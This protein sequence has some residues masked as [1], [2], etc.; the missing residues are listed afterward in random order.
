MAE[1][2]KLE[3]ISSVE[4]MNTPMKKQRFIVD[5]MIYPGL[6]ILSGDPK[7][8]KSWMMLDMCLA[9][10][11][12]EKF[13]GRKTERGQVVYM[14]LED[15]F[16]SL[17]SRMYELTDEPS[18]NLSFSLMANS[19]GNGLEEDLQEC[20]NQFPNLKMIVIDTL[21]KIRNTIDSKYGSDYKELSTLKNIANNLGIAIVL[22]H[23]NRKAHD[24]NP[25]NLIS[26]TNGIAGCA[27]GLLVF[28]RSG[29]NAKLYIS[30]RGAP[31]F[32]M[33]LKRENTKWIL[34]DDAPEIKQDLFSF[35]IHDFMCEKISVNGTASEICSMLKEK[36]PNQEFNCNWLY[37][38]LLQHDDEIR[39]LG[40]DYGK[41]KSNGVR[42]IYIT[43]AADR[44]S[45]GSKILY[46]EN[47]VPVVPDNSANADKNL[48]D[49]NCV[50]LSSEENAVPAVPVK[51][52][53]GN[54]LI[55]MAAEM[56][57][58]NLTRQGIFVSP[59]NSEA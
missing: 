28:T 8:G 24:S 25:N 32:E 39:S 52:A 11:K 47:A 51:V 55:T 45:S 43:Y 42:S 5:G 41:T 38:D 3:L 2:K 48:L 58:R 17:Q 27:D 35:A 4:I 20:K 30:G 46:T 15:T 1:R 21:Q 26:G 10:A 37:R 6:H 34:L 13:L 14:A 59:F 19:I 16:I 53:D 18:E 50:K 12:G 29:D 23:H 57:R 31:S 33:N 44:D 49:V 22:V 7:V 9:V 54:S 56:M 40:I 36:Y